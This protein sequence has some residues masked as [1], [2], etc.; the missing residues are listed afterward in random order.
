MASNS[1][2]FLE[3]SDKVCV[4][5]GGG[6]WVSAQTWAV[7]WQKFLR[8]SHVCLLHCVRGRCQCSL[9]SL[10][11]AILQMLLIGLESSKCLQRKDRAGSHLWCPWHCIWQLLLCLLNANFY[12][13]WHL[14]KYPAHPNP[15]V[16][17]SLPGLF[18]SAQKMGLQR[19]RTDVWSSE[20]VILETHP[21]H[22]LYL[23]CLNWLVTPKLPEEV[24]W[25]GPT[26]KKCLKVTIP[27]CW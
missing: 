10:T 14:A 3:F 19:P 5:V 25:K 11:V 4:Y 26:T 7:M 15:A 18:R 2:L 1:E 17:T 16:L 23:V 21:L 9:V 27:A 20:R 12:I 24:T 6:D 8:A 22:L 13:Q